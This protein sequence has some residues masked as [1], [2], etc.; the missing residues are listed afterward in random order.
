MSLLNEVVLI[1]P[2]VQKPTN[3][4]SELITNVAHYEEMIEIH[5]TL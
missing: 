1:S 2:E 3:P 5:H 4:Y